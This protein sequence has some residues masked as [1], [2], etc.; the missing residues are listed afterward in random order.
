MQVN[1]LF[2][3]LVTFGISEAVDYDKYYLYSHY[4]FCR[5]RRLSTQTDKIFDEGVTAK[6]EPL[7]IN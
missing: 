6:G 5:H 7:F 4:P 3:L 2:G 1:L